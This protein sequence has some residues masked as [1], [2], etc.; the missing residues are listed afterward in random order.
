MEEMEMKR[1]VVL[2]AVLA[3]VLAA[4]GGGGSTTTAAPSGATVTTASG[5]GGTSG[6][7]ALGK[8]VYEQ[9]CVSCHSADLSG[10]IGKPLNAGSP[11]AGDSDKELLEVITNGVSGTSMPA[12][13]NSLSEDEIKAVLAYIRSVQQGG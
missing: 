11:A 13:G 8:Q 6:D 9:N 4:C 1:L 5:S 12:W 3:L 2:I 7:V 10:G